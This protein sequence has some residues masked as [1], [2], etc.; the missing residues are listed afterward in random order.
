MGA[1]IVLGRQPL[2]DCSLLDAD[3][4][5][6]ARIDDL[7]AAVGYAL[8]RC[9]GDGGGTADLQAVEAYLLAGRSR[10]AHPAAGQAMTFGVDYQFTGTSSVIGR[11]RALIDGQ[12][13][14]AA[15]GTH[16]LR[17]ELDVGNKLVERDENN[18]AVEL[19]FFVG[20][21]PRQ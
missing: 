11:A 3:E 12:E 20:G 1:N 19:T 17:W 2:A 18:N 21:N 16:T 14:T 10:V 8:Y 6:V 4:N 9:A 5:Q 7:I 15:S 13:W